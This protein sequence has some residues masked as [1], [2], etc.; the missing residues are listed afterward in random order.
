MS[1]FQRY[2][3]DE[4][5]KKT[6]KETPPASKPQVRLVKRTTGDL[7]ANA[8]PA[9]DRSLDFNRERVAENIEAAW[10]QLE[11]VAEESFGDKIKWILER[12]L[13]PKNIELL[14]TKYGIGLQERTLS[15]L[16]NDKMSTF[17][18]KDPSPDNPYT[19]EIVKENQ[20]N[21]AKVKR[22]NSASYYRK[23]LATE[24]ERVLAIA[25]NIWFGK[26][27]KTELSSEYDDQL[28]G[29]DLVME[30][31]GGNKYVGETVLAIDVKTYQPGLSGTE[32]V[33]KKV[34]SLKSTYQKNL[35]PQAKYYKTLQGGYGPDMV[36]LVV[37][38]D[39]R[40]L[41][42][43]ASLVDPEDEVKMDLLADH[44][45]RQTFLTLAQKEFA[46]YEKYISQFPNT[47]TV[48]EQL[49]ISRDLMT[50]LESVPAPASASPF[51]TRTEQLMRT[52]E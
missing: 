18:I 9:R 22:Q 30:K 27:T 17:I 19:V 26:I 37:P 35:L 4:A 34:N 3:P 5:K 46:D 7:N 29:I 6:T 38:I 48:Q 42:E 41:F 33:R 8:A 10:Q 12:K 31:A 24:S 44:P 36:E 51:T 50:E 13:S 28:S 43:I 16:S 40:T 20:E 49:E 11:E 2:I 52:I 21:L 15:R 45:Y 23:R 47:D 14:Q 1:E 39:Q 32:N 25:L